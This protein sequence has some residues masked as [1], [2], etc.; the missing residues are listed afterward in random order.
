MVIGKRI[1]SRAWGFFAFPIERIMH[2]YSY[3]I[4]PTYHL[5]GPT[6]DFQTIEKCIIKSTVSNWYFNKLRKVFMMIVYV[7]KISRL[8]TF[9]K[10]SDWLHLQAISYLFKMS[11]YCLCSKISWL[12]TFLNLVFCKPGGNGPNN[13]APPSRKEGIKSMLYI[14]IHSHDLTRTCFPGMYWVLPWQCSRPEGGIIRSAI[15][16]WSDC[17]GQDRD[18]RHLGTLSTILQHFTHNETHCCSLMSLCIAGCILQ[19][20]LTSLNT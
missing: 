11:A 19:A 14:I 1:D 8:F 2:S 12:F 16:I 15:D 4:H 10:S 5:V 17:I 20:K 13:T 7:F 9:S 6:S 3:F 18:S